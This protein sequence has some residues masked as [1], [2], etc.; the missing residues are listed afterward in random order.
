MTPTQFS[1]EYTS[2][3]PMTVRF[4]TKHCGNSTQA[5][6]LAQAAWVRAWEAREQYR[7]DGPFLYWVNTIGLNLLRRHITRQ[8]KSATVSLTNI[9]TER[10]TRCSVSPEKGYISILT[11]N[12]LLSRLSEKER[13]AID[14]YVGHEYHGKS[15][16][17]ARVNICRLRKKL[18]EMY[19]QRSPREKI[20]ASVVFAAAQ[21]RLQP[22]YRHTNRPN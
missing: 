17:T 4:L 7:G 14:Y 10:L 9:A 13:N 20:T 2:G 16:S 15:L 6:D 22:D 3:L 18:L 8:C 12:E 11:L 19:R 5:V 1:V 21:S